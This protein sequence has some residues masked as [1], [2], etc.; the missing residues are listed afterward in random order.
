MQCGVFFEFNK[1]HKLSSCFLNYYDKY[2]KKE[3]NIKKNDVDVF[4]WENQASNF[5]EVLKKL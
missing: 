4:S 3:N 1:L 2:L 5:I